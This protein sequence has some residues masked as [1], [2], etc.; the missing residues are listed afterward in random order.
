MVNI[1]PDLYMIGGLGGALDHS[2]SALKA[3]FFQE[4][5]KFCAAK[6]Q[7]MVPVNSTHK[8]AGWEH[9]SAEVQ[10]RCVNQTK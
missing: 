1:G 5:Q 6:G 7:T 8:D 4:A 10:F 3:G 2:G 9:S